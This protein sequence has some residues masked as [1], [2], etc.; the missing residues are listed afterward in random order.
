VEL[1]AG[2]ETL[3]WIG[4][5]PD[6]FLAD[7]VALRRAVGDAPGAHLQIDAG[8]RDAGWVRAW[9]RARTEGGNELWVTAVVHKGRMVGFTEVEVPSSGEAAQ[10]DTAVARGL[11][12]RGLGT[13][14]KADMIDR[15][16]SVRPQIELITSTINSENRP[17]QAAAR[18]VGYAE[19]E[20][21]HLVSA[22]VLGSHVPTGRPSWTIT[23]DTQPPRR[24]TSGSVPGGQ[25]P[26][27]SATASVYASNAGSLT[28]ASAGSGSGS[29]PI[30]A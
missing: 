7:Y 15:L 1:P 6:E 10:H 22:P 21:R 9:E 23:G 26:A 5:C 13:W 18:R 11:R 28:T 27:L 19:I 14:L 20:R 29:H 8:I 4:N 30:A 2:F 16:R 12:G 3:R 25:N 24:Y 17:M